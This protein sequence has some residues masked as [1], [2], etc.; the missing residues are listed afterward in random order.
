[1]AGQESELSAIAARR[2]K[3]DLVSVRAP[4]SYLPAKGPVRPNLGDG[5][6]WGGRREGSMPVPLPPPDLPTCR[7]LRA[8]SLAIK[9]SIPSRFQVELRT[10]DRQNRPVILRKAFLSP[11]LWT[12]LVQYGYRNPI[13]LSHL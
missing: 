4:T 9:P 2:G 13:V 7:F 11:N 1:M 6:L 3:D 8:I 5:S 10:D 12:P